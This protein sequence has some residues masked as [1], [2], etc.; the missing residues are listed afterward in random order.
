MV[1]ES[2]EIVNLAIIKLIRR[3]K[4]IGK[5]QFGLWTDTLVFKK[6]YGNKH[7]WFFFANTEKRKNLNDDFRKSEQWENAGLSRQKI[8]KRTW[9]SESVP[10]SYDCVTLPRFRYLDG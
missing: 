7:S 9:R 3:N 2:Y 4:Q 6:S 8:E 10:K 5:C 1:V